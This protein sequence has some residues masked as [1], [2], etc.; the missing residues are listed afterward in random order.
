[1]HRIDNMQEVLQAALF[2]LLVAPAAYFG[3]RS[4]IPQV[5]AASVLLAELAIPKTNVLA[6]WASW[7]PEHV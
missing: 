1:M 2:V 4:W 5:S 3:S 7:M 6:R